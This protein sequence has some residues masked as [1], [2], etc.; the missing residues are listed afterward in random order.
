M[1]IEYE[2]DFDRRLVLARGIGTFTDRDVF[3]YQREVWS[4]PEV[5]G[6]DELVDMT[7][8]Q[9][10][11]LPSTGR[12][13][14]LAWLAALMDAPVKTSKFAI[15]APTDVAFGLGRMYEAYRGSEPRS[16]KSVGVF[17]TMK[18]AL[19]FLG[20]PHSEEP[21]PDRPTKPKSKPTK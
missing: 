3:D 5:S 6:F 2:I 20:S 21:L 16:T 14:D 9:H 18:E 10:I 8:V 19:E 12:V 11:A 7:E 15:V 17:R 13:R 1:P 4:R